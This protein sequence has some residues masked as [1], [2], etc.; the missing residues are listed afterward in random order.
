MLN[1]NT[2][3]RLTTA[4][5][6]IFSLIVLVL[7]YSVA[8]NYDYGV[9]AG[10]Y[11]LSRDGET[12]TLHLKSDRSFTQDLV[13]SGK[14]EHAQ[15]TWHRF[16][17]AHVEFSSEFLRVSGQELSPAGAAHGQ[18]EKTFGIIPSL[19]LAPLPDGP[20]FRKRILR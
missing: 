1:Q 12:C 11:V 3:R 14:V 7:W 18:F 5:G 20:K 15:G 16:G 4:I 8:A 17:E 19:T 10:T 9:L 2:R 13:R 6:V